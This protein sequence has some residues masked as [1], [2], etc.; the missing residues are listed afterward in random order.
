[1]FYSLG[2]IIN[3]APPCQIC[4]SREIKIVALRG[5]HYQK[6]TTAICTGC[7]L[8]HSHPIPTEEELAKYYHKEYRS[9]YKNA[10]TPQ[11]NIFYAMPKMPK[12]ASKDC[13]NFA[14]KKTQNCSI[15][16]AVQESL[17][18]PQSYQALML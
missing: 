15:L 18:M 14:R 6:L 13:Y 11:K 17:F 7:G 5:R 9:A 10:F 2:Q 12:I 16:A 8:I 3:D 1:M 4:A